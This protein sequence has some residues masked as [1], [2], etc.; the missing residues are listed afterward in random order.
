ML[1]AETK[2]NHQEWLFLA[3][4][5]RDAGALF[6]EWAAATSSGEISTRREWVL[7]LV[8]Q[9]KLRTTEPAT[10][11]G[12]LMSNIILDLPH[13][14]QG[15]L[16]LGDIFADGGWGDAYGHSDFLAGLPVDLLENQHLALLG[17]QG[18]ERRLKVEPTLE[19][20]RLIG[21][22]VFR[23]QLLQAPIRI[24][25]LLARLGESDSP[26]P[27]EMVG[28]ASYHQLQQRDLLGFTR[29]KGPSKDGLGYGD[30]QDVV[31]E[32]LDG[33]CY[34]PLRE[35][36]GQL[37]EWLG[38]LTVHKETLALLTDEF[39]RL[40]DK[41][42]A[43]QGAIEQN[44][45]KTLDSVKRQLQNL[46]DLRL[47]DQIR[48]DEYTPQR[49]R[50]LL[51]LQRLE[52]SPEHPDPIAP[53]KAVISLLSQAKDVFLKADTAIK[54]AIVQAVCLHPRLLDKKVLVL[55]QKPFSLVGERLYNPLK[56]TVRD[57]NP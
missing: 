19:E 51:E 38:G 41:R 57:L 52:G 21:V 25:T 29:G 54:R 24:A 28:A 22:G 18:A 36:E 2:N 53:S 50:L 1:F 17:R 8:D 30:A 27:P 45:K 42:Q 49:Q 20:S 48:D 31:N 39:D 55:A 37:A 56:W 26:M 44:R 23:G 7:R 34:V 10:E 3:W 4:S 14:G 33:L 6:R 12:G 32:V 40:A 47:R 9:R 35:M 15:F 43:S 13:I 5:L 11:T 46:T 16:G